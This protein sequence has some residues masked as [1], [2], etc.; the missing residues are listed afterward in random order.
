MSNGWIK[1]DPKRK[2]AQLFVC[3]Y[4]NG[5]VYQPHKKSIPFGECEYTY[6]PHCRKKVKE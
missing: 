4:C 2:K 3:P 5:V 1:V 6:C